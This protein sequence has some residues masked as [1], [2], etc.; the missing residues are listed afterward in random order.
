MGDRSHPWG[1]I[2]LAAVTAVAAAAA[3]GVAAG[4]TG[5]VARAPQV[6]LVTQDCSSGSGNGGRSF[7]CSDFA[8][9]VKATH[10]NARIVAPDF[11]EDL[12]DT[13]SLLARQ[14]T[15]LVIVD[16][17][18]ADPLGEAARR[19]PHTR[20]GIIDAPLSAVAGSPRNVAAVVAVPTGA[21]YLAGWLGARMA[22]ARPGP[23]TIGIVAGQ[24]L[25]PVDAFT[26][27]IRAGALRAF[28]GI[29]VLT[30]YSGDF[31]D[32]NKCE[33]I[34]RRQIAQ[35]ARVLFDVA[36]GC[37]FGTLRA[38][39][40]AGVWAVGVDQDRAPL[41]PFVLTSMVKRYDNASRILIRGVEG[42][43]SPF[44]R[45]TNLTLREGGAAL[46]RISP[47]VPARVVAEL[48]AVRRGI[49][50]GRIRVPAPPG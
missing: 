32:P 49:V 10:A 25:P 12:V 11:R 3:L 15:D 21:A 26:V 29:R 13:L 31:N 19:F 33:A 5:A 37:G 17:F 48:E 28:H 23:A 9:A 7:V 20:F 41:G 22:H 50:A 24:R 40:Q 2:T 14:G 43:R 38:A 6:V 30:A 8:R 18:L 16:P 35:G 1:R 42:G 34:A 36:G 39:K 47:R 44:G 4:A 46:G 27:G 45:T